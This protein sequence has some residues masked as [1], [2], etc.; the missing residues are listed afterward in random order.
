[1]PMP[2]VSVVT[3]VRNGEAYLEECIDSVLNQTFQD[4]EYIIL[5]NGSTDGTA[6]ILQRYTDPRLRIIHQENLGISRSLNK[7]ID[8]SSS[9]L[10]ARLDA[11]DYSMPQML[12]KLVTFMEKHPDIVLCGSR[13]L[14]LVGEKLSKQ[15]VAFVETDQAIKKTMSLFNPFSHSAVIF[16][17]KTFITAG[18]YSERFKYGQ[19]YELWSRMLAFGKTLILKEELAVVRMSE[20]SV[21]NKNARKQKLEALQIRWYAF[22]QFG[23]NPG[24]ALYYFLKTLMGLIYPSKGHL[25][26]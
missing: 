1:M 10:I 26:P 22:Q 8:L 4:F 18:G 9:D 6:R 5:N 3:S 19:D 16:R 24:Q 20:Q 7:G 25:H 2:K 11:D 23:G 17:K 21:S 12:E 14:E 13:W 15:I